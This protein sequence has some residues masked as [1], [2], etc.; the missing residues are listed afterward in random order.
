V[1]ENF[2]K[3][4]SSG[5]SSPPLSP[6]PWGKERVDSWSLR[7][8]SWSSSGQ[9]PDS[10]LYEV[11]NEVREGKEGGKGEGRRRERK[12]RKEGGEGEGEW[13]RIPES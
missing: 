3:K 11:P 7:L 12:R 1:A 9:L 6:P 10:L 2:F 8:S 5:S 13:R 4:S